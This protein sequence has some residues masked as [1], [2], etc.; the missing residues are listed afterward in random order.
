MHWKT[1]IRL[2]TAD[3]VY[4]TTQ[5]LKTELAYEAR[6]KLPSNEYVLI[7]LHHPFPNKP[8]YQSLNYGG[9]NYNPETDPP[10]THY[11]KSRTLAILNASKGYRG[12]ST[13][14]IDILTSL[15]EKMREF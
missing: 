2:E 8:Y 1:R 4:L 15:V 10:M 7:E 3:R 6:I 9:F 13:K 14:T 5:D 12:N 11:S